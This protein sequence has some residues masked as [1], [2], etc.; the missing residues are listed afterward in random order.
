MVFFILAVMAVIMNF[1]CTKGDERLEL[2]RYAIQLHTGIGHT[3]TVG[4][5]YVALCCSRVYCNL[6]FGAVLNKPF[7][8][9][10]CI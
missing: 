8:I 4:L 10:H 6:S 9:Y 3:D 1:W 5:L 7:R 2:I